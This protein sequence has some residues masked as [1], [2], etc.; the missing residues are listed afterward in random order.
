MKKRMRR[1]VTGVGR[2]A[3]SGGGETGFFNR[4]GGAHL[5]EWG[6][7]LAMAEDVG[8]T[9]EFWGKPIKGIRDKVP[10]FDFFTNTFQQVSKFLNFIT[11]GVNIKFTHLNVSELCLI[12]YS[13]GFLI[14]MKNGVNI[15]PY[16][17]GVGL[18]GVGRCDEVLGDRTK[19]PQCYH[20]VKL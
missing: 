11:V 1:G 9:L 7:R 2:R 6:K 16:L 14:I 19:E 3:N 4:E 10:M 18:F 12:L 17:Y 13:S 15:E 20:G 8:H 5:R